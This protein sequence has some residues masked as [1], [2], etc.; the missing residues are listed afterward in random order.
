MRLRYGLD[1][2]PP[3]AGTTFYGLQWLAMSL[4][5]VVIVG[6]VAAGHDGAA[7]G[8]AVLYLQKAT[9]A[10]G[11]MLLSQAFLGHRLTL[12]AGPSTALL[13]G[14]L[15]SRSTPDAVYT[16]IGVC[17]LMLAALSAGGLFIFLRGLF[18]PRVTATV[19]LLI[20]FTMTP[21]IARLLTSGSGG[22]AAGRLGYSSCLVATLFVAHRLL[23][24]AARSLLILAGMAAGSAGYLALF[25]SGMGLAPLPWFAGFFSGFT[26]PVLDPGAVFAFLFCFLALSVN[27]IGSAQAVAPLLAPDGMEGR[28]KRGMTVTGLVNGAAGFLGVIG[29]VDY[30]LSPGVIAASGCGSRFPL[31]PAGGMLVLVSLSP[32]LLGVAGAIPPA[33]VG[34]ILVYTLAGQVAAGMNV[35]L[36]SGGFAFED[37]LVIGL[38]V[39]AGTVAALL[40]PES[41]VGIPPVLRS[42][43]GNGFVAGVVAVL[44]LDRLFSRKG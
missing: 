8:A 17:G 29:P 25:G 21:T 5:F 2:R 20:A 23:P 36:G 30:S 39:L 11:L 44:L 12:V 24:A 3:A 35:A 41:L 10:T 27:E 40:P 42:V 1:D 18:T 26:T 6:T 7:G 31:I 34:A 28:I 38:P 16:A 32:A 14:I 37:G 19:L 4:P 33:V 22:S 43:A 9:F 13:M 15:G